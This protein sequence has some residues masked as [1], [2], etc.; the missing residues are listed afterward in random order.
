MQKKEAVVR[1]WY[2]IDAAGKPLG[3]TA[4]VAA[5]LLRG[6][7]APEFTPHVDCGNFVI[8]VNAGINGSFGAVANTLT[9]QY[10][11]KKSG[12]SY[13]SWTDV[14]ATKSGNTYSATATKSGFAYKDLY[15]FQCRA[16]DKLATVPTSEKNI[17]SLPVY[18]WGKDDFVF[19]VPVTFGAGF[20]QTTAEAMI[21]DDGDTY[22]GDYVIEQGSDG[23][24]A[25]RKWNSGVMEAWRVSTSQMTIKADQTYTTGAYYTTQT[26]FRT[27]GGAAAFTV[28]ENVQVSVNKNDSIGFWQPVIAKIACE[29]GVASA[30][31]FFTNPVKDA[32]AALSTYVYFIGRWR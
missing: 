2:V 24:Y 7:N 6:K 3:R 17:K 4:V 10:R 31:I 27:T 14:T 29:G 32:Q 23:A 19:N 26:N 16:V 9:V 20:T 25:Y 13:S 1:K 18:D 21:D 8:I 11:W 22:A 5:D 12:G 28:L 30:S 15:V